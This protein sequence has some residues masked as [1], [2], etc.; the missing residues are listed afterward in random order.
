S[1]LIANMFVGAWVL[2]HSFAFKKLG[3]TR[4]FYYGMVV[5][6]LHII[7]SLFLMVKLIIPNEVGSTLSDIATF[8]FIVWFIIYGIKLD[9]KVKFKGGFFQSNNK[10]LPQ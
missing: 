3:H 6:I 10:S 7:S 9:Q 4:L 5:G 8:F 2:I 1:Y